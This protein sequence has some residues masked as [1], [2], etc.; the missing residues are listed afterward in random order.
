MAFAR[1][2]LAAVRAAGWS[3]RRSHQSP[4]RVVRPAECPSIPTP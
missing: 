4:D 3:G 2:A 1:K